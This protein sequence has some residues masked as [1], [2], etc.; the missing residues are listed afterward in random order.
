MLSKES[1]KEAVRAYKE[2]K[3]SIGIYAVRCTST[4]RVWVGTSRNLE[5]TKNGCWFSLREGL[6]RDK[7]LQQEWNGQGEL[8]F[9][10]DIVSVLDEDSHPFE[11]ADS[12]K[13]MK[14]DWMMRLNAQPLL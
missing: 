4:G 5:A 10:Y 7:P 6:H 14:A 13:A 2:K 8:A 11:I 12:L 3:P 1:R 9:Q